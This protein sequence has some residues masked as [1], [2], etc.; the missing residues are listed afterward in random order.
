MAL[1]SVQ[2]SALKEVLDRVLT[3]ISPDETILIEG[4]V[5]SEPSDHELD[6]MLGFG[7]GPEYLF[8]LPI[9]L[10]ALKEFASTATGDLAKKWGSDLA[11]WIHHRSHG[12]PDVDAFHTLGGV[13]KARLE[14]R[15][16]SSVRAAQ[17]VDCVIATLASKPDLVV[18]LAKR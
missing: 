4:S 5:Q 14:K 18:A 13:L 16:F 6:G 9:L 10:E 17:V 8:V 12:S 7:L 1:S 2:K 3:K 15:G 11:D